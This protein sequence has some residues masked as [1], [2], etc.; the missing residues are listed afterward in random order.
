MSRKDIYFAPAVLANSIYGL[1][2]TRV[3]KTRMK[4]LAIVGIA[5]AAY[6]AAAWAT[7]ERPRQNPQHA[8]TASLD[9]H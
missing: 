4:R 9:A 7:P 8:Q 6:G 5:A 3:R 1:R 2:E